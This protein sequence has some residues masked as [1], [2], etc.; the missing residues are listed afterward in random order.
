MLHSD[1]EGLTHVW[2]TATGSYLFG[3]ATP[4]G[5]DIEFTDD[6]TMF[7]G[8]TTITMW[9]LITGEMFF[10]F[11]PSLGRHGTTSHPTGD[12]WPSVTWTDGSSST[13]S[14]RS[15]L[16]PSRDRQTGERYGA[17]PSSP[18]RTVRPTPI[19]KA[20]IASTAAITSKGRI[21]VAILPPS[22][23]QPPSAVK[24]TMSR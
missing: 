19:E 11:P 13:R 4:D 3:L 12:T 20:V 17:A 16:L 6:T 24:P 5:G 8:G 9:N 15:R 2:E 1:G 23:S 7:V 14:R 18:L 22:T 10:E 21:S